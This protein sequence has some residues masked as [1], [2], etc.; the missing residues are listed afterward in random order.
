[1]TTRTEHRADTARE[2]LA[3]ARECLAEGAPH[4]ASGH[5]WDA[6]AGMVEAVADS[7]GWAH[8]DEGDLYVAVTR[9]VEETGDERLHADIGIATALLANSHE[10]WLPHG[11]VE[12]HLARVVELVEKLDALDP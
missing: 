8:G 10:D 6:A 4:R 5:G 7:R 1:M 11:T 12:S 3:S 9:L 2:S